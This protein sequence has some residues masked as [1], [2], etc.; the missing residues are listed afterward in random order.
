MVA[1]PRCAALWSFFV[2]ILLR[3]LGIANNFRFQALLA[4]NLQASSS[5]TLQRGSASKCTNSTKDWLQLEEKIKFWNGPPR[6][7]V[8]SKISVEVYRELCTLNLKELKHFSQRK[9][10]KIVASKY[11]TNRLIL[12]KSKTCGWSRTDQGWLSASAV[13][14]T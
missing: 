6:A 1:V 14:E 9:V 11:I 3:V 8:L 10:A 13:K 7:R 2:L 5:F 12:W 4:Q